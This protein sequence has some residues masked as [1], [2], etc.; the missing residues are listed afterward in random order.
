MSTKLLPS[1]SRQRPPRPGVRSAVMHELLQSPL[2]R[3]AC[4]DCYFN[5]C[6]SPIS[7]CTPRYCHS[8]CNI[9]R[10]DCRCHHVSVLGTSQ[11]V[12]HPLADPG[13]TLD[14]RINSENHPGR[15]IL[16]ECP[17]QQRALF[18]CHGLLRTASVP[19]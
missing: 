4:S 6:K 2:H 12:L 16:R 3:L 10:Y 8:C 5:Y 17:N 13:R 9:C 11:K 7:L 1:T 19:V 14:T 15:L 18:R